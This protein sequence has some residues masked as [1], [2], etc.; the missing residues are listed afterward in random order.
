MGMDIRGAIY[1]AVTAVNAIVGLYIAVL[2]PLGI[3]LF[4][5]RLGLPRAHIFASTEIPDL[6]LYHR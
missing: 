3:E 1:L 5:L 6:D 2:A 4:G